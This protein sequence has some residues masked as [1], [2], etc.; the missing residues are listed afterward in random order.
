MQAEIDAAIVARCETLIA[1][2]QKCV[3]DFTRRGLLEKD[4]LTIAT[5]L[6]LKIAL[7]EKRIKKK[8]LD[9]LVMLEQ[10]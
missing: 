5:M 2:V 8:M 9:Y 6:C 1:S 4:K 3:Y 7:D 10:Q